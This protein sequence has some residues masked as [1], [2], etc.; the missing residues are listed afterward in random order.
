MSPKWKGCEQKI[1]LQ[2]VFKIYKK[3]KIVYKFP[4]HN[5]QKINNKWRVGK[6]WK[7]LIVLRVCN[8]MLLSG[9]IVYTYS[10][11]NSITKIPVNKPCNQIVAGIVLLVYTTVIL[12]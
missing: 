6:K 1:K 12:S 5:L 8:V 10:Q 7:V 4:W 3:R 2:S 11:G 9:E